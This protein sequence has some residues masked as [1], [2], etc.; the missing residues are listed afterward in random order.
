MQLQCKVASRD[1]LWSSAVVNK[2]VVQGIAI[3]FFE[4]SVLL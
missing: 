2:H 1:L 4:L 3:C